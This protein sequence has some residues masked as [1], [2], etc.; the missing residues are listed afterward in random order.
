MGF[1]VDIGPL[2]QTPAEVARQ[3]VDADVHIVGISSLAAGHGTLVRPSDISSI[4]LRLARLVTHLWT[5][6]LCCLGV[7]VSFTTEVVVPPEF[8]SFWLFSCRSSFSTASRWSLF[9][10]WAKRAKG[11][12]AP[13]YPRLGRGT[14][15]LWVA[16]HNSHWMPVNSPPMH[17]PKDSQIW[18]GFPQVP[19]LIE[20]L[21]KE[22]MDHVLVVCGGIIPDADHPALLSAGVAAIY[23]PGTRIPA[24]AKD[25]VSLL[26]D[27]PPRAKDSK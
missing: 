24:A 17:W 25:L 1:D 12:A 16:E 27:A 14:E 9:Q 13:F 6:I 20:A 19:S 21:Q 26:L 8:C 2:F 5:L 4:N 10:I 22:G 11:E 15:D 3:A 7:H 18:D 23:G